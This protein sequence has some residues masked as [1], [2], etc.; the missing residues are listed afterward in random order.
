MLTISEKRRKVFPQPPLISFKRCKNLKDLLFRAKLYN[1]GA[2]IMHNRGCTPC[3]CT[4]TSHLTDKEYKIN[5]PFNCDLP[6]VVYLM[7]C[8]VCGVQYVCSTCTPFRLRFNNYKA[9]SR[10][11][12]IVH[13]SQHFAG[14]DHHGFLQDIKVTILERMNGNGRIPESFWQYKLK[15]SRPG[16][17]ILGYFKHSFIFISKYLGLFSP[18]HSYVLFPHN[19]IF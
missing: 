11:C 13:V 10:R 8:K 6:N 5:F 3:G 14:K 4:F 15:L 17:L 12:A 9:C 2:V 7:E 18:F 1:E 16:A 19:N